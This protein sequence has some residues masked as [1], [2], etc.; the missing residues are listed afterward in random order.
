[1]RSLLV[2]LIKTSIIIASL[3]QIFSNEEIAVP[4]QLALHLL[5]QHK[6]TKSSQQIWIGSLVVGLIDLLMYLLCLIGSQT[7]NSVQSYPLHAEVCSCF[8]GACVACYDVERGIS[9]SPAQVKR[10]CFFPLTSA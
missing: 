2:E 10:K 6:P 8:M 1:M 3:K 5:H 4:C 9:R 7:G